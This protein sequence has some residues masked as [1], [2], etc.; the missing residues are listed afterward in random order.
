MISAPHLAALISKV[1]QNAGIT[2]VDGEPIELTTHDFRR[3]F[4]TEAVAGGLPIH[5]VAKL[6][7]HDSV[8]TTE[9]YAAIYPQDVIR[10]FHGFIARRRALRPTEEYRDPTDGEW[11]E[12]HQHFQ[13]RKVELGTCG[14]GYGTPCQHEHVPLTEL[15]ERAVN[16]S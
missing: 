15:T 11:E 14:R 9:Y 7:G 8:T 6:L 4:A 1:I 12:F 10:H 16:L 3:A 2:G 13:R 5:I